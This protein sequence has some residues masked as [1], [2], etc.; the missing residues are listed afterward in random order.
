MKITVLNGSPRKMN[1]TC[2][3]DAFVK[4]AEEAGHTVEVIQVGKMKIAGCLGCEYCHGKGEGQ[5]IQ[6]DD[7]EKVY[8][9]YQDCDMI[10]FAS[11]IYYFG[12]TAQITAATQRVYALMKWPK[13]TKAALLLSSMSPNVYDGAIGTYKGILGFTGIE[14]MGIFTAKDPENGSEALQKEIYDFAKSL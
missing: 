14:D 1:T 2:M 8:P 10:V 4:G 12:M 3:V 11:P 13:A 7:M 5:C 6:K 9:A